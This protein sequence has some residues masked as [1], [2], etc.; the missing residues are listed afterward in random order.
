MKRAISI[1]F[2]L[3]AF[4][5]AAQGAPETYL[6]PTVGGGG[7]DP[8]ALYCD[9]SRFLG[10]FYVRSGAWIDAVSI[11]CGRLR[12]SPG[13]RNL[14]QETYAN[15][16]YEGPGGPRS[17][18]GTS[19]WG[20]EGGGPVP[21]LCNA[22]E[23]VAGVM[24]QRSSNNFVGYIQPRC[25]WLHNPRESLRAGPATGQIS[26][27]SP[28][29]IVLDC[30]SN[31]AAI[32][33][34]GA[35]GLFVDRLGLVCTL[36]WPS[37]AIAVSGDWQAWGASIHYGGKQAADNDAVGRCGQ[38]DCR[39]V[40]SGIGRCIAIAR[41]TF[42]GVWYGWAYGNDPDNDL[43][44]LGGRAITECNARSQGTCQIIH[45]NCL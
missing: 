2:A 40:M 26:S 6:T 37:V 33:F 4:T 34:Y 7:G 42:N 27:K 17:V 12:G 10:G 9:G 39:V 16:I 43:G 14:L 1:F 29:P 31:M 21:L 23:V 19:M 28:P 5:G 15:I 32:G 3:L 25:A 24:I 22:D 8:L 36:M 41:G 45:T 30:P 13:N 20:G 11:I 18:A 44:V 35:T 38:W